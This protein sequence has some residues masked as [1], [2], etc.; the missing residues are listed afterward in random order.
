[1]PSAGDIIA[2]F[3]SMFCRSTKTS[4]HLTELIEEDDDLEPRD[5]AMALNARIE[6]ILLAGPSYDPRRECEPSIPHLAEH[7]FVYDGD[8]KRFRKANPSQNYN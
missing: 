5:I 3:L 6:T 7:G 4:E 2:A 8:M 1:M